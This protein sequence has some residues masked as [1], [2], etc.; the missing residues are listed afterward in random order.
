MAHA[1]SIRASAWLVALGAAIL[2]CGCASS[3]PPPS[4]DRTADLGRFFEG[5]A[6][7]FVSIDL[8]SGEQVRVF[9]ERCADRVSPCSTF[10][11]PH[12][13]IALDL[14][15]IADETVVFAWDGSPKAFPSWER[16]HTLATAIRYSVVWWFQRLAPMIGKERMQAA[17][18]RLDYGNQDLSSPIDRFWLYP[19]SL[20]ISPDEQARFLA[21]LY[22]GETGFDPRAVVIVQRI[23]VL[24]ST[25]GYT[26]SG[27][28]GSGMDAQGR[29]VVNWFIG[30]V[31]AGDGA[32]VFACNVQD[33]Q[34]MTGQ[35]AQE[36]AQAI[37]RELGSLP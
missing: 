12:A 27:K 29:K 31:Q 24:E 3:P 32:V 1:L 34:G 30:H 11:V 5:R 8:G 21:R 4:I 15:V 20:R 23:I 37:L 9:P 35:V 25:N 14:G 17:L 19:N 16:D 28:T 26:L 13:L 36:A 22:R 6:G 10:K 2:T 18:A 7:A 33:P